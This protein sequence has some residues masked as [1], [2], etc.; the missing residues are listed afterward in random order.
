MA[1]GLFKKRKKEEIS[2]SYDQEYPSYSNEPD[3][4]LQTLQPMLPPQPQFP[5]QQD[6]IQLVLSKLEL[7]NTKIDNLIQ[8]LNIRL[9]NL[10]QRIS[11]I[12]K[13]AE[14]S[15]KPSRW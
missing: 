11:K 1:F 10:E 8:N 14:E 15:Q 7:L 4:Q 3:V 5:M 13:I 9:Q 2:N 12:E 6:D